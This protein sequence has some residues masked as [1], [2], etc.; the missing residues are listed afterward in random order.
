MNLVKLALAAERFTQSQPP[1]TAHTMQCVRARDKS[2]D[3]DRCVQVCPTGAISLEDGVHVDFD[4]CIRCGLC[5]HT[6]PTGALTGTDNVH[7]L[8]YCASQLV[9]HE[10]IE[11]ACAQHPDPAPGDPKADAVIT[12][13]GCLAALGASAY[14]SLAT[15]GV[16]QVRVRLD[17]CAQCPLALLQPQIEATIQRA[18]DLLEALDKPQTVAVA[19]PVQRPRRRSVYS[20]K[21]PPVTRRSF[22][23]AIGQGARDFLPPLEDVTERHRLVDALRRL[24]P[25]NPDQPVPGSDFVS[26]AI[27]DACNACTTCARICPTGA[28]EFLRDD[29]NF[30]ITF[31]AAACVNCGLCLHFCDPKALTRNG[32]PTVG[33]LIDPEP[34]LLHRGTLTR[35]IKCNTLFAGEADNGLCPVCAFRRDNPFGGRWTPQMPPRSVPQEKYHPQ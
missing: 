19:A 25:K 21:N 26:L 30:E 20:I 23:Q 1:I 28:L 32:A 27:S 16:K 17:A 4:A 24:A 35:C 14:L 9:D 11:I 33:G 8:L 6:C 15:Q 10:N 29:E 18:S 7:R 3:C 2:A 5:L 31:S 13:T 34:V 22:F 12:T